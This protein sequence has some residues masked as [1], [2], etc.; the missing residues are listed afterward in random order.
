MTDFKSAFIDTAIF[1]YYIEKS[2]LFFTKAKELFKLLYNNDTHLATSS[3]T[4]EEYCVYP[5]RHNTPE[6]I[7]TFHRFII[8]MDI[9]IASID[10]DIAFLAAQLRVKYS[11]IK[12]MDALQLASAIKCQCDLFFTNDKQLRQ[13][14][15][16]KCM[17]LDDFFQ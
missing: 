5:L 7:D 12:A 6:Y 15:E 13:I 4:I 10:K 3:I 1:I 8:D 9:E 14:Q 11:G 17:T 2:D 16:I